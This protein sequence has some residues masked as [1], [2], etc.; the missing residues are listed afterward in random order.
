MFLYFEV[1]CK[2]I[3]KYEIKKEIGRSFIC[4]FKGKLS[5][6]FDLKDLEGVTFYLKSKDDR[7]RH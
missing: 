1:T 6:Y 3:I 4:K 2:L 5:G 7:K